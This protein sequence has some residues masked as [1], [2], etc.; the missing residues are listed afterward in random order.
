MVFKKLMR[1]FGVGGPSVDTILDRQDVRPGGTA[2]GR[3]EILG[4]DHDV[5]IEHVALGLVTRVEVEGYEDDYDATVEFHRTVVSGPFRLAAG[6]RRSIP[7]SFEVP[8]EAPMTHVYGRQLR[9]MTMGVRTEL[10][11]AKAV[12]KGDLDA[13]AIYPLSS[14]ER[15][16]NAFGQLGFGFRKADLERG[17][18][19]GLLQELPFFQ[20]IEFD[21]PESF[22]GGVGEV[23]LTF[24]ADPHHLAVVLEADRRGAAFGDGGDGFGRWIFPHEVA[25]R[26]DWE[27]EVGEWLTA[28]ADRAGQDRGFGGSGRGHHVA[29]AVTAG[30]AGGLMGAAGVGDAA[31][32]AH[33]DDED[34][35]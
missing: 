22:A 23:E 1:A 14:Q 6:E 9:G 13:L 2:S 18:I 35:P 27:R 10:S 3:V 33:G 11:V 7:F 16:L 34:T 24:I 29:G 20:E 15:V 4:G 12:D 31:D 19:R 28:L 17:R 5:E 26:T 32:S 30:V 25:L 21:V 8:F